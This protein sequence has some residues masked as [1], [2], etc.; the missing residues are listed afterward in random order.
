[1][2]RVEDWRRDRGAATEVAAFMEAWAHGWAL[3]VVDLIGLMKWNGGGHRE[4]GG[5]T[6]NHGGIVCE[7]V[8]RKNGFCL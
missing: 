3:R 1:V 8:L 7:L 4:I 2:A 6:E 5:A